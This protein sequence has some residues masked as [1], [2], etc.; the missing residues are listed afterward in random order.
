[1]KSRLL[2]I[3]PLVLALALVVP[4]QGTTQDRAPAGTEEGVDVLARGPVHEAYAEPVEARPQPSLTVNKQPP[5][6]I[7][8][9]PPDQKPEA[10]DAQWI[11]GYW[12][13]DEG[14]QDFIWVSGVW[15][16]PPPGRQWVAGYW[17]QVEEG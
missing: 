5:E 12:S 17:Q 16:I 2:A 11:P 1:M 4:W 10:D 9:V 14:Q 7:N 8:E 3:V 13:W 6:P 15:R